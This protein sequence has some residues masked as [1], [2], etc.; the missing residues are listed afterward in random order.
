MV[1]KVLRKIFLS[2]WTLVIGLGAVSWQVWT[3]VRPKP[4][5]PD[6]LQ[7][8]VAEKACW[9]AAEGVPSNLPGVHKLAVLRLAGR[10]MEG[11]VTG[12]L[13]ECL[14]RRGHYE[15]LHETFVGN[16]KR[17][18]GIEPEPVR[19]LVEALDAGKGLK[20]DGVVF[21]E[22]T[23]FRRDR[24]TARIAMDLKVAKVSDGRVLFSSGFSASA[25]SSDEA[26]G[27]LKYSIRATSV[28]RRILLWLAFAAIAPLLLIPIIRHFLERESNAVNFALLVALT[29]M[30]ISLAFVLCGLDLDSWIP[31]ALLVVAAL[32][33]GLYNY[34][35][36]STVERLRR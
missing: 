6:E 18:L 31:A 21:G 4:W 25:P 33:G 27:K 12:K 28:V 5:A 24:A 2:K 17:E 8:G 15:I 7:A 10:D 19:T 9:D 14:H 34:W 11:F 30:D 29:L 1:F 36:C 20:V 13:T 35:L 23:E 16:V 3:V 32:S 26:A 22:V